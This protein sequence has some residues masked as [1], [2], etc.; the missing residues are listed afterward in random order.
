M[1]NTIS[2]HM[3]V[4]DNKRATLESLRSFR[5][6]Y[7][8]SPITVVSDGGADFTSICDAVGARYLYSD[9]TTTTQKMT[10]PGVYEYLRR[11]YEHCKSVDTEWVI[12]FEDDVRVLRPI[13]YFPDGVCGGPRSL[14]YAPEV[15]KKMKEDFG[16]KRVYR[17]NMCG[18]SIFRREVF[19]DSYE[20]NR[21]LEPYAKAHSQVSQW[22]DIAL[23]LLF[24]INGYDYSVWYEVSELFHRWSPIVRDSAIDHAYKYWYDK[25]FREEM[26]DEDYFEEI[27][28]V[29]YEF[30]A[31]DSMTLSG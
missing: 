16:P 13:R 8:D 27:P 30:S 14:A 11:I 28:L 10:L 17:Y 24:Q 29:S 6:V 23:T 15:T 4:Y 25:P 26:L 20:R 5:R 12:L 18:G 31:S 1:K 19:I 9:I 3:Q 21:D 2:V 22:S 7:R